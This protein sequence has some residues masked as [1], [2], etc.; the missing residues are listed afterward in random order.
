[1]TLTR[2]ALNAPLIRDRATYI[3]IPHLALNAAIADPEIFSFVLCKDCI[4]RR[5]IT[6][7]SDIQRWMYD[8]NTN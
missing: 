3:C 4:C 1:M 6:S 2:W 5:I 8:T 7:D